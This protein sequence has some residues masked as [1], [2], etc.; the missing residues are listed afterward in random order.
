MPRYENPSTEQGE[1][2]CRLWI[3]TFDEDEPT[4]LTLD[5]FKSK[6]KAEIEKIDQYLP[7]ELGRLST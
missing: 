6:I 4:M 3:E 2:V 5:K 7:K 1:D